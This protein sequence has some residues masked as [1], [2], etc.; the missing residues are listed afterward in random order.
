M[1]NLACAA[2][3]DAAE[4]RAPNRHIFVVVLEQVGFTRDHVGDVQRWRR[5]A[6]FL[7]K[8]GEIRWRDLRAGR[9]GSVP[10]P[11]VPWQMAQSLVY[12]SW[13]EAALVRC[14]G[15]CLM[16]FSGGGA[17]CC[18]C[19]EMANV[20]QATATANRV[21]F[22]GGHGLPPPVDLLLQYKT[23]YGY[24]TTQCRSERP[25]LV[26]DA[27]QRSCGKG[28]RPLRPAEAQ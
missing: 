27:S 26:C 14:T 5:A 25:A 9:G 15:T 23:R 22:A 1:L 7:R 19:C 28:Q 11:S 17:G 20:A 16:I 12:I 4:E 3:A 8:F 6:V 18:P 21:E 2:L 13:P 10:A 24:P